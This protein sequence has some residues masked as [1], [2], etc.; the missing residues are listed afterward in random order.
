MDEL[1]K[2][3]ADATENAANVIVCYRQGV[4]SCSLGGVLRDASTLLIFLVYE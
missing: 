1:N 3:F 2:S 4:R